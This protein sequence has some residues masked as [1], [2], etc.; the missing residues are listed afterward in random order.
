MSAEVATHMVLNWAQW[1]LAVVAVLRTD[2]AEVLQ[3]IGL[4]EVDWDSWRTFYS[5]GC[6]PRV[7]VNRAFERDF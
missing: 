3:H 6:S 7:A 5:A 2:F 1:Q 4:D